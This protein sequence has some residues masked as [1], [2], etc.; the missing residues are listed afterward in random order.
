[1]VAFGLALLFTWG[2][3]TL[4]TSPYMENLGALRK[5]KLK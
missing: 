2:G 1:M 4:P 5:G 3:G